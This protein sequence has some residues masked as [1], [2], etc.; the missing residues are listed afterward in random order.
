[1][2][3]R[4]PPAAVPERAAAG[5]L[6]TG[7][8]YYSGYWIKLD[9]PNPWDAARGVDDGLID[10]ETQASITSAW[11]SGRLTAQ[12]TALGG[13]SACTGGRWS[14]RTRAIGA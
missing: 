8:A 4:A 12:K 3:R 11:W 9:Y 6:T 2:C 5:V 10:A 13:A 7:A 1:M 14:G